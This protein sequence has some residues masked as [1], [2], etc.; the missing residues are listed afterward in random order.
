MSRNTNHHQ[1]AIR[2]VR[3]YLAQFDT[4][5]GRAI[6]P[7]QHIRTMESHMSALRLCLSDGIGQPFERFRLARI[8]AHAILLMSEDAD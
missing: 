1:A 8:A 2:D 6:P 5:G 4:I 7:E 3:Q